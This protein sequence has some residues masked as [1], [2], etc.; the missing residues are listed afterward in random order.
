MDFDYCIST[1]AMMKLVSRVGKI[2]G[3]RGMMPSPKTGTVTQNISLAISEVKKGKVNFRID[4]TGCL[5]LGIGKISFSKEALL[6]NLN[7]F[8]NALKAAKPATVKGDFIHYFHLS[9]TM[10]PSLKVAL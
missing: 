7:A 4:K 9:T 6:G 10:S 5:H 8:L 2:L 1:P 3:P